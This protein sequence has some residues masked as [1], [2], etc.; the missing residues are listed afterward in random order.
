MLEV[1]G[2]RNA[3]NVTP[4][5][6][7]IGEMNLKY[8][9]HDVGGS[10]AGVDTE[11]YL[12]KNPNGKIPTISDN[13]FILWE[14]NAIVRYLCNRYGAGGLS[15]ADPERRAYADQWMDW[16]KTTL[17]PHYIEF[18][19]SIVRTEPMLRDPTKI[20][21]LARLT[22]LD[23][24]V[25][26]QH[27]ESQEYVA[28][29]SLTMADIP[30]GA[31]AYRLLHIEIPAD[32]PVEIPQFQFPNIEA[33]YRRLTVRPA[34]QEHVMFRFGRNPGEWYVLEREGWKGNQ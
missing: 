11:D 19:W 15:P 4:V 7:A 17:Y 33:W 23:L 27:L 5:M 30:L 10:F 1:W 24:K 16:H 22:R 26:D 12:A 28:G 13:G 31:A 20:A 8:V 3:S 14:S 21:T 2:R 29:D 32:L 18:F 34:Y 6:W 9:R 25:L